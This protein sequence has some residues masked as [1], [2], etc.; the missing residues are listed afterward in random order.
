MGK[1]KLSLFVAGALAVALLLALLIGPEASSKPDGL[2]KVAADHGLDSRQQAHALKGGPLAG[3]G[4]K[5][6]DDQRM[7]RGV[8]GVIGVIV[9]FALGCGLFGLVR[10]A[11]RRSTT[12]AST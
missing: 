6:V 1:V 4:I 12:T 8:A 11:R 7:S 10:R 2:N 3:Y 5:G 9:T